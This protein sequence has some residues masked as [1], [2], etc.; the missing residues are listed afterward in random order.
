[1]PF[2]RELTPEQLRRRFD[3][4]RL[5]YTSTA[6]APGLGEIIGQ[7]RAARAITFGVEIPY[8]GFN[9]FATGP[10]GAG[11]T[12]IITRFLESKAATRPVPPDW[13]YVHNFMD[14]DRPRAVR[15]PPGGGL[16]LRDQV[17][18]LLAQVGDR[19]TQAFRS[20]QYA[21]ARHAIGNRLDEL[22]AERF[23]QLEETAREQG[24][25]LSS[26]S[27][28]LALAPVKEGKALSREE[29]EAL[30]EEEQADFA[31][32]GRA[33]NEQMERALRQVQ[34]MEHAARQQLVE[35][36]RQVAASVIG[37]LFDALIAEYA[38]WPDVAVYLGAARDHIAANADDFKRGQG[39]RAGE[40]AQPDE[41]ALFR[42]RGVSPAD[43]YRLNLI[44][45]NSA[46]QGAP[47]AVET[48]PT[49][50][51][52]LGRI[53]MRTEL[54]TLVT[55]Y[56]YIK[57]GALHHAIGGYLLLDAR[58]LLRQPLAWEAL[59]RSLRNGQIRIE[60]IA[61]QVG[62][63][64]APTLSPEPIPL[65]TKVVLIGDPQT[66]YLLYAYDEQ[67]EKLFKVRADFAT[68]MDRTP[69]NELLIVRFIRNRC[70]EFG[71]PHFDL[72][73]IARVIEHSSRLVEDQ[74][75]LTT[76]FALVSDIVQEAAF[77]ATQAGHT[78]VCGDDVEKA[79]DERIYRSNQYEE[80]LR[81]MVSGG[82]ILIETTGARVGQVNGLSVIFLGDHTF[83][84][85]NR[86]SART[87]Q[88]RAGVTN[89]ERESRLSGKIHDKGV[90]ILQGFL[91]GR[92]A[93]DKPL[94]LSASIAFEQSYEGID[95][96]SAS[97]AELYALLSSLSE[98]PLRQG[99]AVTGSVN[100]HGEIQAI[101][102]V[103][104][105]VEGFFDTCSAM[106]GGLAGDQGVL[107]PASNAA[108][109]MLRDDVVESVA[110]GL[111]HIWTASSVDEGIA[112]LT[113]EQA[114]ERG[115]DG[116]YPAGSVNGRV[117]RK[118][119]ELAQK[120]QG[121]G[122]PPR[123][124]RAKPAGEEPV[125]PEDDGE[126]PSLPGEPELPGDRPTPPEQMG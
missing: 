18:A 102:G 37:P 4:E 16:K 99:I 39:E 8:A 47:L 63:L 54:G 36:D 26:S 51:N 80:R 76:R 67:F 94:S 123:T 78:Q 77:W 24:F 38:G 107:I 101:G 66:Y 112:L 116:S 81:E 23:R 111:F 14:P 40:D 12:S 35:L 41:A 68:E 19:L 49:Y 42:P 103:T 120:L 9:I 22:R 58:A 10:A 117:D 124:A 32:H 70:D 74:R 64:V 52:L 86:I 30:P 105:K 44:V 121:F 97:S 34:E 104:A 92:Y 73:A 11:K 100:Q 29:F 125:P 25:E 82:E 31:E 50:A 110:A 119:R 7:D 53:E 87:Y 6:D 3:A 46:L 1:M 85:P 48:N 83:G 57:A 13:G 109:L 65:E 72:S 93:Q 27:S 15:L 84:R 5:P 60:D 45:D 98:L 118:L 2:P 114:G 33:V 96:D 89:I 108:H 113:G 61:Q 79:I 122:Q 20:D 28:G 126:E 88:G 21:E 69:E 106:P 115:P 43:R 90:L 95:G 75:K 59:K 62:A 55:D 17:N 91:G 71:L 56:R